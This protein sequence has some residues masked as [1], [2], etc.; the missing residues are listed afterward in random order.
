MRRTF[1]FIVMLATLVCAGMLIGRS[2]A[3]GQGREFS[4]RDLSGEYAFN[5]VDI[6]VFGPSVVACD[7]AGTLNF[8]GAGAVAVSNTRR[9][10]GI[11]G[12]PPIVTTETGTLAYSVNP[13][14]SFLI[15]EV[16]G[17]PD[18]THGQIA[19][20]GR[21]LLIDGT[22]RTNPNVIVF[23]GTAVAR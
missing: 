8:D 5:L 20:H 12:G 3:L 7:M 23:N 15:T 13:D 19:Q 10:P 1:L 18:P 6:R 14:G 2:P 11:M 21:I 4:N 17:D 9:C 22:T 16:T